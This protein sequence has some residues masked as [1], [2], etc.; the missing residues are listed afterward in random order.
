MIMLTQVVG[1]EPNNS[2]A[3]LRLANVLD[4]MGQKAEALEIVSEGKLR[5]L[6]ALTI[7]LRLRAQ[8][9]QPIKGRGPSREEQGTKADKIA[10]R[11]L[12][13]R[14]L[15]DQMKSAMQGLWEQVQA[16]EQ[17]IEAVPPEVGAL[18]RFIMSAGTMVENFRLAKGNF[19]KGRV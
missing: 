6:V 7:V 16:A 1:Q 9:D 17:G 8:N 4:D 15:E 12:N 10:S 11:K 13:K 18:D 5:E 19:S 14:V 2:E 3:R